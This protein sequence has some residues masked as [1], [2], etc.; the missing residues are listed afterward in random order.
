MRGIAVG[1]GSSPEARHG[2][3]DSPEQVTRIIVSGTATLL[4]GHAVIR[5]LNKKLSRSDNSDHRENTEGYV[6]RR[7]CIARANLTV[8]N[9]VYHVGQVVTFASASANAGAFL[10]L[11]AENDRLYSLNHGGRIVITYGIKVAN[12]AIVILGAG[13]IGGN[14]TLAS[15]Q[16]HVLFK[17]RDALERLTP[18]DAEACLEF[19]KNV[20]S[21]VNLVKSV[22]ER[23]LVNS[24][25]CPKNLS[26][27]GLNVCCGG[28]N[29]LTVSGEIY[30][31]ILEA[32]SVTTTIEN[33]LGVY[34]NGS[35]QI[36]ITA[37][38]S[39]SV[40]LHCNFSSFKVRTHILP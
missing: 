11:G 27:L 9:S 29:F 21:Y 6:Y 35:A 17:S 38:G 16:N 33:S 7:S 5:R 28:E 18:A 34:A 10:D 36:L 4:I 13:G 14:V 25:V 40:F 15:V 2:E 19:K 20:I 23:N 12:I 37:E 30:T 24:N 22:I 3:C 32:I 39:I 26:T 31:G 8:K 1:R